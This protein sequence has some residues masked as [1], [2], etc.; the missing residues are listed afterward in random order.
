MATAPVAADGRLS[1][2]GCRHHLRHLRAFQ[3]GG[4]YGAVERVRRVGESVPD[5]AFLSTLKSGAAH[6]APPATRQ[7]P[8][9]DV[10]LGPVDT[11]PAQ[12]LASSALPAPYQRPG[13]GP[14]HNGCRPGRRGSRH[15]SLM[16][17]LVGGAAALPLTAA[18]CHT[19][20][21][22]V[23]LCLWRSRFYPNVRVKFWS[24]LPSRSLPFPLTPP[25]VRALLFSHIATLSWMDRSLGHTRAQVRDIL[26]MAG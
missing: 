12:N 4:L 26:A 23:K 25:H 11:T 15:K 5:D 6:R 18:E 1:G 8:V 19:D 24:Y 2:S 13:R 16:F 14:G 20:Q 9:P 3:I 22:N 7:V 17:I 10:A 21:E